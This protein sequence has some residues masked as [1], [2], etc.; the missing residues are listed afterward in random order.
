MNDPVVD[1]LLPPAIVAVLAFVLL[2]AGRRRAAVFALL[3]LVLFAAGGIPHLLIAPLLLPPA[4]PPSSAPGAIVVL[5]SGLPGL[6]DTSQATSSIETLTRLRTAA[7]LSRATGTPILVSGAGA[8]HTSL[9]VA[10]QMA[11]TLDSDFGVRATWA[12][13]SST[14][15]WQSAVAS[16][17]IL[18]AAGISEIYLV[19]QP[20]EARL[21]GSVFRAA[22][23][24]VRPALLPHRESRALDRSALV[25]ITP[26]WLDSALA[27]RQ[28]AGLACQALAPCAS[29][30]A[31]PTPDPS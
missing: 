27:F 16:A 6:L 11:L 14:N 23:L 19:T 1:A 7:A 26:A 2:V 15:L 31:S 10:T 24:I 22:G 28:W 13:T 25:V 12:E 29:W 8:A 21:S 5:A 4:A 30:M 3:V 17:A 9:P 18:Q 20:W